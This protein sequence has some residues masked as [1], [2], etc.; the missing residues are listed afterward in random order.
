MPESK[1]RKKKYAGKNIYWGQEKKRHAP[2]EQLRKAGQI[3]YEKLVERGILTH[4]SSIEKIKK[5]YPDLQLPGI[6]PYLPHK[7]TIRSSQRIMYDIFKLW[8][9][10][11]TDKTVVD[12]K[13]LENLTMYIEFC[14]RELNRIEERARQKMKT[15]EKI[16]K[17]VEDAPVLGK[18][19]EPVNQYETTKAIKKFFVDSFALAVM[20]NGKESST[21]EFAEW[22]FDWTDSLYTVWEKKLDEK[23]ETETNRV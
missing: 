8:Q 2:I 23:K 13:T 19:F 9:F 18:V 6:Y 16:I 4:E 20:V 10:K 5:E 12:K 21:G 3:A 7:W 17:D 15:M 22:F 11:N 14:V 1:K